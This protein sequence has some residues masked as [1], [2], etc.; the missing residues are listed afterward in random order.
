MRLYATIDSEMNI[1][2]DEYA[3]IPAFLTSAFTGS[4]SFS[5]TEMKTTQEKTDQVIGGSAP[6]RS[7]ARF[8]FIVCIFRYFFSRHVPSG[9]MSGAHQPLGCIESMC[10]APVD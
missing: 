9:P 4:A 8:C 7:R 6:S 5:E 1:M 10:C 3:T 2:F